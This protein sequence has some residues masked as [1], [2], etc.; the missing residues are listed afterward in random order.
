[1]IVLGTTAEFI[2]PL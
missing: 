1:M 2:S